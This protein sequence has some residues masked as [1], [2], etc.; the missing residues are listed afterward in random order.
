MFIIDLT[1]LLVFFQLISR[2][3]TSLSAQETFSLRLLL[4]SW[5]DLA[6]STH[7][8]DLQTR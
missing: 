2:S 7:Y 3:L 5:V 8:P 4:S 6:H 1:Q